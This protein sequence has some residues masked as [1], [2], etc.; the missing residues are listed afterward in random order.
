M[1][2]FF[3]TNEKIDNK[4]FQYFFWFQPSDA[5]M[6]LDQESKKI[7]LFLDGRYLEKEIPEQIKWYKVTKHKRYKK[8][9]EHLEEQWV[10]EVEF[11]VEGSI[12]HV[13]F[14][15]LQ[16]YGGKNGTTIQIDQE[17]RQIQLRQ[18]KDQEELKNIQKAID[19]THQLRE[20]VLKLIETQEIYQHTELSLKGLLIYE[21]YKLWAEWEAFPPIVAVWPHS[22]I[23]HHSCTE[24]KIV[25]WVLLIDMWRKVN[26]YCSDFTRTVWLWEHPDPEFLSILEIVQESQKIAIK[27]IQVGVS[28]QSIAQKTRD[29]ISQE[30]YGDFYPHSLW[31]G[32]WC[33]IHESPSLSTRSQEVLKE[34]MVI[35]IEPWIYLPGKFWVRREDIVIV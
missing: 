4:I 17:H 30:G 10:K 16:E 31:H 32:V 7:N 15:S 19:L 2:R 11:I 1:L 26:W 22:A 24:V 8:I 18:Q 5:R 3:Y 14:T 34:N 20:K 27:A 33:D 23:P 28:T 6:L 25:P 9:A 21:A 35:T 29:Y 12:P 13:L